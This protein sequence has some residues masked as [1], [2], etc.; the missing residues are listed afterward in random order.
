VVRLQRLSA[1]WLGLLL[2]G[3]VAAAAAERPPL[4]ETRRLPVA[5][6]YHGTKVLDP[7]RWLEKA[8]DPEVQKWVAAQNRHTRAVLDEMP[9]LPAI[10]KRLMKLYEGI[11][12]SYK[13]VVWQDDVL[14]ALK[15]GSLVAIES[16]DKPEKAEVIVDVDNVTVP[17]PDGKPVKARNAN[18]DLYAISPDGELAAVSLSAEGRSEGTV[19]VYEVATGKRR[20]D[21]IPRAYTALGGN[22]MW[23]SDSSGFYYTRHP[24][25]KER[26][27]ADKNSYQQIY[28]HKLG[29]PTSE[30]TYVFGKG[31]SRIVGIALDASPD[32]KYLLASVTE[33]TNTEFVHYLLGPSG[34]WEQIT[35]L[36]DQVTNLIF[37]PDDTLLLL[38]IKDAPRG[39]ILQMPLDK[40]KVADAKVLVPQGEGVL[41]NVVPADS[42][43]YVLEQRANGDRLRVF[44][45]EGKEQKPVPIKP[46]SAVNE[47]LVLEEDELLYQVE[48]YLEP[49]VWFRYDPDKGEPKRT[50]LA[51]TT[52]TRFND[53]EVVE[54]MAVSK[55][56]T[57][58]P[59]T[60]VR[61][62][63][64]KLDGQR[65]TLL[66]GYGGFGENQKPSFETARRIWLDQGGI[67]AVA[68]VRGDGHFGA[69]WQRAGQLTKKQNVFD[70]FAACAKHLIERKYTSPDKLAIN[71]ASN[72]GLLMGAMITQHPELFRAVVADCG[73]YDVLRH[74]LHPSGTSDVPEFGTVKNKDHFAVMHGYS[75]YHCVKDGTAYPAV[76]IRVGAN[77]GRVG[78]ENSWK[79]AARLQ[80]ATSSKRPVLLWTNPNAGHDLITPE[81]ALDRDAD[82]YGFL[83][84]QLGVEFK[85]GP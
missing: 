60:I 62:K 66:T 85:A 44:D 22:L 51:T 40:P 4:P 6:E 52:K 10:Q 13:Q 35:R 73:V 64:V 50:A 26:P 37:G 42:R 36:E 57:K 80:A 55:D 31:L 71:G 81:E 27:Y 54:E 63:G 15:D 49:P 72:G 84:W 48:T 59:L 29:T 21:E 7:Y 74:E 78:P 47:L 11:T 32:D 69:D 34:K 5:D 20:D 23:K 76:F 77:D 79:L 12:P 18:I 68:H 58:V 67:Y 61:P 56:G 2:A 19:Y 38:S 24:R 30:D 65:P 82:Y 83:F 46:G 53:V 25:G 70:D 41:Q 1:P 39:Q 28:F 43:L 3:F 33:G 16:I 14:F 17:G 9:S 45:L 75:P 8:D